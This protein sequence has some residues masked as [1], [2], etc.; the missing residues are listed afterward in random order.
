ME[1]VAPVEVKKFSD[2]PL[3]S[4]GNDI[5]ITGILME[6]KDSET[7]LIPLPQEKIK[8]DLLMVVPTS[9]EWYALQDQLDKCNILGEENKILRKGQRNIDQKIS[10]AVYRRD[11]YAC[12]YCGIDNVP[13]T[14]DHIITWESGG[15]SHPDNLLTSCKKCNKTRGNL[16][17]GS[18]L[19]HKYYLAKSFYL[20]EH[21]KQKNEEIVKILNTLPRM[22]RPRSR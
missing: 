13:L 12:R 15:A 22:S 5:M 9:E 16:D 11:G 18:W 20:P 19:Q 6:G 1:T 21:I 2:I 7:Y 3:L 10:W 4:W 17:Y 14:V 8:G